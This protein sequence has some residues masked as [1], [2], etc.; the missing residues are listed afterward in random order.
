MFR[1]QSGQTTLSVVMWAAGIGA[2]FAITVYGFASTQ[3]NKIS[4]NQT[5]VVQRVSVVET[6]SNQYE[7]DI[8]SINLKLDDILNRLP[9]R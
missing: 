3:I 6:K 8:T 5:Q 2:T 9:K 1:N 7:K 4:E